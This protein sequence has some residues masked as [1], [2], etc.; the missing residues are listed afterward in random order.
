LIHFYKRKYTMLTLK[1]SFGWNLSN[2]RYPDLELTTVEAR[3]EQNIPAH[4]VI[5]A[6]VSEKLDNLCKE[7][8]RVVIRNVR[9]GVLEKLVNLIYEGSV[10]MIQNSE[11]L[12]D[13]RDAIDMLKVNLLFEEK[14]LDT[15]KEEQE[16]VIELESFITNNNNSEDSI[17][18]ANHLYETPGNQLTVESA[19]SLAFEGA[20]NSRV[21]Q[22]DKQEAAVGKRR[23]SKA[24]SKKVLSVSESNQG[25]DEITDAVIVRKRRENVD[26]KKSNSKDAANESIIAADYVAEIGNNVEDSITVANDSSLEIAQDPKVVVEKVEGTKYSKATS[27][28]A[29]VGS[30]FSEG[31]TYT[32]RKVSK[33]K[34]K[35]V[36]ESVGNEVKVRLKRVSKGHKEIP[37]VC[38]QGNERILDG[39]G[40]NIVKIKSKRGMSNDIGNRKGKLSKLEE[41]SD[42]RVDAVDALCSIGVKRPPEK[43]F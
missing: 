18:Q 12:S 4:R 29:L 5:M 37:C 23:Q 36:F 10:E 16:E 21:R 25:E 39:E 1:H 11:D 26:K 8:G 33:V 43:F 22:E 41:L 30:K 2:T 20:A 31:N 32:R 17:D 35:D 42:V 27:K 40:S 9:Y 7:G 15:I 24:V 3:K 19:Y 13:L 38:C 14:A 6:A 28:Q 34:S